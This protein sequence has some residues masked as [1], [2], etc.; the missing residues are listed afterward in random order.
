MHFLV[1]VACF[2]GGAAVGGAAALALAVAVTFAA[3]PPSGGG[4]A[5]SDIPKSLAAWGLPVLTVVVAV[6]AVAA[7]RLQVPWPLHAAIL[8]AA[9]FGVVVFLVAWAYATL[10]GVAF[11][12][13]PD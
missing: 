2:L 10:I 12:D 5:Y 8:G 11:Q 3:V 9:I 13:A 4:P 1:T 7:V 6:G